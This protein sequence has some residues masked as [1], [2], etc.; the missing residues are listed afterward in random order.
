MISTAF[1]K[2]GWV[3][4]CDENNNQTSTIYLGS[5]GQL[6]GYTST[7]FSIKKSGWIEVYDERGTKK[8]S[9]YVG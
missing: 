7:T 4:V 5:D 1:E 3:V 2:S 9:H 6:M 8:D